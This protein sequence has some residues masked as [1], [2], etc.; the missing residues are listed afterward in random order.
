MSARRHALRAPVAI[1]SFALFSGALCAQLPS[2]QL[3]IASPRPQNPRDLDGTVRRATSE[4]PGRSIGEFAGRPVRTRNGEDLGTLKDI[5]ID[6]H[7]GRIVYAVVASRSNGAL[8]L[9]PFAALNQLD[10]ANGATVD[11]ER[12][13]WEQIPPVRPQEFEAGR[14]ALSESDRKVLAERFGKTEPRPPGEI[15]PPSGSQTG[16]QTGAAPRLSGGSQLLALD[17]LRG[18]KVSTGSENVGAIGDVMIDTNLMTA[19][20]VI[21]VEQDFA[22]GGQ[23]F[24]V[25]LRQLNI[26]ARDLN[27]IT[28]TLTRADFEKAQLAK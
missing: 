18:K 13:T 11:I 10:D 15:A 4:L 5:V 24:I 12:A 14:L 9:V 20:A 21:T 16:S 8:R 7:A 19:I 6:V 25:P 17:Q 22:P 3:P 23:R 27:P 1:V 2:P 28:T 26:A